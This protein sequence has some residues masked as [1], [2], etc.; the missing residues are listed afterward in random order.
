M[1]QTSPECLNI[2]NNTQLANAC[3]CQK[4]SNSL[5]SSFDAYQNNI[6]NYNTNTT[7]Y[8]NAWQKYQN[9]V[10]NWNTNKQNKKNDLENEQKIWN[11]CVLWTGVYGH[12]DWCQGDTGFGKQT[13][14]GQYGCLFGQGKGECRRTTD[15]VNSALDQWIGSNPQ[16]SPPSGGTNGTAD[17]CSDCNPPNSNSIQ[18]CSQL[19]S[20]IAG[21]SVNFSNIQQQC[22]QT[23]K[24]QIQAASTPTTTSTI[25]TTSTPTTSSTSTT[26]TQKSLLSNFGIKSNI[27][28]ISIVFVLILVIIFIIF[29]LMF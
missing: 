15:Q 10:N 4:A 1:S 24:Q 28:F 23:I 22:N 3:A 18:C 2:G 14:A 26:S 27:E 9:D 17:S 11:H 20:N 8:N 19:F 16:P 7:N 6:N 21:T 29:I 13:G 25:P 5:S 12:D